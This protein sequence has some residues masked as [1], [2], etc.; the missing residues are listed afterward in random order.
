MQRRQKKKT[1]S[2]H[3]QGVEI[4][5]SINNTNKHKFKC[6]VCE[7]TLSRQAGRQAA[8]LYMGMMM[9]IVSML[10]YSPALA[11]VDVG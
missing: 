5:Q 6:Q 8:L 10:F 3:S 9:L 11:T 4:G 1:P 7:R 2:M